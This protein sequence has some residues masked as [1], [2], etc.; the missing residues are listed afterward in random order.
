MSPSLAAIE[1][2][3]LLTPLDYIPGGRYALHCNLLYYTISYDIMLYYIILYYIILYHIILYYMIVCNIIVCCVVLCL[4]LKS[5]FVRNFRF[6]SSQYSYTPIISKALFIQF[7]RQKWFLVDLLQ[8]SSF[9]FFQLHF[10][11]NISCF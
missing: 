9:S 1:T 10:F 2:P 8:P 6:L 4:Y 5:T 3:I 11:I 7:Y